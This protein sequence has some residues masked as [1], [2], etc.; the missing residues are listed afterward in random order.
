MYLG[1][2][3][4]VITAEGPTAR[5]PFRAGVRQGCP[6]SPLL[7]NIVIEALLR[8][9]AA[10]PGR[11]FLLPRLPRPAT[12]LGYADDAV[13]LACSESAL[14]EQLHL[15]EEVAAWLGLKFKP[16]K[17]ASLSINQSTHHA[18]RLHIA[19]AA[20]PALGLEEAYEHL[21][22]ST[23]FAIDATPT[24]AIKRVRVELELLAASSLC[25]WQKLHAIRTFLLPQ[26]E[27][28]TRSAM[29][30]K[31]GF[32]LL[33]RELTAMAKKTMHVT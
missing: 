33:D 32:A 18:A 16:S 19:G 1:S 23:G 26:L 12:S 15:S 17:C 3:T 14:Q 10:N 6:L 27:F 5:I 11:G 9:L 29:V 4:E 8:A 28:N 31:A 7:F 21:G 30:K 2:S 20:L 24:A 22:V 25:P 13:V